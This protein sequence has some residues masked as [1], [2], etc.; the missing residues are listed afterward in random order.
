MTRER[1]EEIFEGSYNTTIKTRIF[2]GMQIMQKY[3]P[4]AD[5]LGADHDIVY[6]GYVDKLIEAGITEEDTK[7]LR[8]L[9][10]MID[11]ELLAHF[12]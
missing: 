9:G 5:I 6:C 3:I 8:S 10:W 7:E 2:T 11:D 1:F 4:K 12:A